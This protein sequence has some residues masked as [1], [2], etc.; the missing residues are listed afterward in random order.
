MSIRK[1]L[2]CTAIASGFVAGI[3]GT[4]PASAAPVG[5]LATVNY[6]IEQTTGDVGDGG[7]DSTVHY[8]L[9]SATA[10]TPDRTL[11]DPDKDDREIGNTDTYDREWEGIGRLTRILIKQDTDGS[12][13]YLD[14]VRITY[15]G[16][17]DTFLYDNWLPRD[18]WVSI[19]RS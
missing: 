8:R 12:A 10:C 15:S 1:A 16:R 14:R 7:T 9:C 2:V 19:A 13:W 3:G 11:D 5:V 6:R 4:A 18:R 17:T